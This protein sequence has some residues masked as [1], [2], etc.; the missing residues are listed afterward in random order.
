L[1]TMCTSSLHD[2]ISGLPKCEHHVHI[3]G[4]LTPAMVFKLAS[5]NA[6][7]LPDPSIHPAY[8]SPETLEKKYQNLSNLEEFLGFH[9]RALSVLVEASDF[10]E[11]GW[12]YFQNAHQNGV[13]HTE[14]SFDPQ[15]HTVRDISLQT[16]I[17]GYRAAC[18]RA[19]REFGMSTRLILCFMRDLP[20]QAIPFLEEAEKAGYFSSGH[21]HGIGLDSQENG[22]PP[23]LF[24]D[25]YD[26]AGKLGLYKTAHAGEDAG[27]E[28]VAGSI[29][30]LGCRRIDHGIRSVEDADLLG[31]LASEGVFVTL[32]PLS[33]VALKCVPS[34]RDVPIRTFLELGIKFSI[35]SDDPAYFGGYITANFCAVQDA[36]DLTLDDWKVISMNAVH[37]SWVDSDRRKQLLEIVGTYFDQYK[38]TKG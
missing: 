34:V 21:I 31:R 35:N 36:F 1:Y 10:E 6:V 37:G 14:L 38:A 20:E 23:E 5:K 2:F 33:N 17:S 28:Y 15:A 27:P 4:C 16:V 7:A 19:E 25:L 3:E 11:L 24:Q 26:R 9:Y 18:L 12:E 32:C 30:S 22:Y 13:I 29:D 8:S